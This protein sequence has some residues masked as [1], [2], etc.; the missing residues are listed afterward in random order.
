MC[1]E[2]EDIFCDKMVQTYNWIDLDGSVT[3]GGYSTHMVVHEQ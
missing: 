2:G 1:K 3:Q